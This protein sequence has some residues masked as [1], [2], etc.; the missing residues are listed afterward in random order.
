MAKTREAGVEDALL[1]VAR[2]I[3]LAEN[4]ADAKRTAQRAYR[5]WRTHMELL[6]K[7]YGLPF[8]LKIFPLEFDQLHSAG[9]AFAGT[10]E[11]ARAYIEQQRRRQERTTLSATFRSV[12]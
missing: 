8:G 12:I 5:P 10:P 4:E 6:W 7:Q 1:G 3:V 9:G 2:H 11:G